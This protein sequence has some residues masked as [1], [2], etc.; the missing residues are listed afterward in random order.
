M[1]TVL[2]RLVSASIEEILDLLMQFLECD[3]TISMSLVV[4]SVKLKTTV[5]M[6]SA[7]WTTIRRESV[8]S[9]YAVEP[10]PSRA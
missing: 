5:P 6:L 3:L 9:S 8:A 4:L 2:P 10:T 7:A 1:D